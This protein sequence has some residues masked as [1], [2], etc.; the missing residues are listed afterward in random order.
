MSL[1]GNNQMSFLAL[2]N[3][4]AVTFLM[5]NIQHKQVCYMLTIKNFDKYMDIKTNHSKKKTNPCAGIL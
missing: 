5:S 3:T 1:E 2:S 4:F